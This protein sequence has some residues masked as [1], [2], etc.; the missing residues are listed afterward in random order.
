MQI[1]SIS[2]FNFNIINI[3]VTEI[4]FDPMCIWSLNQ[5]RDKYMYIIFA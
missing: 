5:T 4:T 1:I 3:G 2:I